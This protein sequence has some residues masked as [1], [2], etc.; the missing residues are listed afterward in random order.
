MNSATQLSSIL[1]NKISNMERSFLELLFTLIFE[2]ITNKD[3]VIKMIAM[4][5][6]NQNISKKIYK[7]VIQPKFNIIPY[8][9]R[10]LENILN[11]AYSIDSKRNGEQ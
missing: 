6:T 11:K 10:S 7:T 8:N 1:K 4:G 5:Q 3:E 9:I 2:D